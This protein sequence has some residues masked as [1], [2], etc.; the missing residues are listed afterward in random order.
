MPPIE[1]SPG[2]CNPLSEWEFQKI[3]VKGEKLVGS[4]MFVQINLLT[5]DNMIQKV[6]L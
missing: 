4:K 5:I 1:T 6:P 3:D 2:G